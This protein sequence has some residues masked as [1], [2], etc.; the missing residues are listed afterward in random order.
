MKERAADCGRTHTHKLTRLELPF[1]LS[2][3]SFCFEREQ[4]RR[5]RVYTLSIFLIALVS[6][7]ANTKMKENSYIVTQ[8]N[9][10][11][12]EIDDN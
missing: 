7:Q 2:L 11:E 12:V 1:V 8:F 6:A 3:K 9:K 4:N 10:F 5:L